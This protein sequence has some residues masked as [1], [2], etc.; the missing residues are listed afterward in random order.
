MT[1]D[2]FNRIVRIRCEK[3]MTTLTIKA[4]EYSRGDRLSNFKAAANFLE[5]T[6]E[7]ALMGMRVK[8]EVSIRD[9]VE[10][11]KRGPHSHHWHPEKWDEKLG[12]SINYL[13]LLEALIIE[14]SQTDPTA[15]PPPNI[16]HDAPIKLLGHF[17][18]DK[19]RHAQRH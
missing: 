2:E 7:K 19:E 5:C 13:I 4:A 3:I 15:T 11:L 8:H 14:R 17:K 10:D 6:P 16:S 12:D 1:T 18:K 9:M